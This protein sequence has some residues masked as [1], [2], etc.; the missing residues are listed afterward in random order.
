MTLEELVGE[1][2]DIL[3]MEERANPDWAS[4]C[5]RSLLTLGRL[6][7]ET[8]PEYPREVIYHYLDDVDVRQKSDGYANS[9]RE[10]VHAWLEATDLKL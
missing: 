4:I 5:E 1:V 2:R 8:E 6:N 10:R 9:Q 7:S 3:N